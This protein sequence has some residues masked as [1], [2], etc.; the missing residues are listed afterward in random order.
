MPNGATKNWVRLCAAIDG[1][2]FRY[3]SWPLRVVVDPIIYRSLKAIFIPESFKKLTSKIILD[4]SNSA[5][6]VAIGD[7]GRYD[8]GR[9]GF[10]ENQPDIRAADWLGICPDSDLA[11]D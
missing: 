11:E 7:G 3:K 1:F 9:E 8:Y 6:V 10:P 2:R 5:Q 4:T